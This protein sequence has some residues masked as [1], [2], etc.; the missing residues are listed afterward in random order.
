[1]HRLPGDCESY[2]ERGQRRYEL[3]VQRL[4][5]RE[6]G[7]AQLRSLPS[8]ARVVI[9]SKRIYDTVELEE[10]YRDGEAWALTGMSDVIGSYGENLCDAGVPHITARDKVLCFWAWSYSDEPCPECGERRGFDTVTE[11][12]W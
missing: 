8:A 11:E 5:G 2:G 4:Q 10:A 9:E 7:T 12:I 6:L 3:C 1:M